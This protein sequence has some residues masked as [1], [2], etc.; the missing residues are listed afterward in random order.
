MYYPQAPIILQM[1]ADLVPDPGDFWADG[2]INT[3]AAKKRAK[4]KAKARKKKKEQD[5]AEEEE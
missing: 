2:T 5:E 4:A 1:P 3:D